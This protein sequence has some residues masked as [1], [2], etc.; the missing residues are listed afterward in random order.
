[1]FDSSNY[2]LSFYSLPLL[3][4]G[5]LGVIYAL[6]IFSREGASTVGRAFLLMVLVTDTWLL[7]FAA[8]YS[9]NNAAVAFF[10]VRVEHIGVMSIP[11][12]VLLFTAAVTGRLR[13]L[14]PVVL[15]AAAISVISYAVVFSTDWFIVGMHHYY[16]GYYPIYGWPFLAFVA[17]FVV[18]LTASLQMYRT[19]IDQ[20]S[21][22]TQR[23][24]LRA[25]WLALL[26]A[27]VGSVDYLPAFH[28]PVY[29]FGYIFIGLFIVL[30]TRAIWRYRLVDITPAFAANEIVETMADALVVLDREGIIRAANTAAAT[31]L[32]TASADL[33]GLTGAELDSIWFDGA[34]G[35]LK[36][37]EAVSH[38]EV[39]YRRPHGDVGT[40]LISVSVVR[41]KAGERQA[42]VCIVHDITERKAA[43]K[44]LQESE[45]LYRTLI[46]TSPDA[47][48]VAEQDGRILMANRRAAELVGYRESEDVRGKNAMEFVALEDQQRLS[49]SFAEGSGSVI[50]RDVEYTLVTK[51][52]RLL[53][54]ELSVSRVQG[55]TGDFNGIMAVARDISERKRAEETIRHLAFHDPL[56]GVANR[57]V[58]MEHLGKALALARR[59]G[60]MLG[61]LFLDLDNFK[62]I[63]DTAGHAA[64]DETLRQ[65]AKALLQLV[66]E[67]DT[68]ARMGGDEFV[69]LLPHISDVLEATSVAERV[70]TCLRSG[71]VLQGEFGVTAS[72]GIAIYP[73]DGADS[74]AL[75]RMADQAMYAAK[76]HGGDTYQLATDL[77]ATEAVE[78]KGKLAG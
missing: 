71:E 34:L 46:E 76:S 51:D 47:V 4:V 69:I 7:S 9:T 43:E 8:I 65:A 77:T 50:I 22:E 59:Q 55:A 20:T 68:L 23:R 24:R 13:T 33:K 19:G 75:L 15:A 29:P 11:A 48:L 18:V 73:T 57:S 54:A 53:P 6:A 66:R 28:V 35:G 40:A 42:T 49:D 64:G 12:A 5:G 60:H 1:M 31:M 52:G 38:S 72:V 41:D 27:D 14:W 74:E 67:G 2:S 25:I 44:T 61:L 32:G 78:T 30:A 58:L 62:E 3:V 10:W 16:W 26:I 39:T 17:F 70:I 21:S 37:A 56:T 45:A 63:N 36:A